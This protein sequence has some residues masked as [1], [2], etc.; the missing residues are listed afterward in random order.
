MDFINF[1]LDKQNIGLEWANGGYADLH[2]DFDFVELRYNPA[3]AT[4]RLS[5]Q[6]ST[7]EWARNVPWPALHLVF[8]GV[9]YLRVK[10]RDPEYP[11]SE[12]STVQHICRTPT[13]A[14]EEFENIYFN[15]DAQPDYDVLL[16]FESEWGI[17]VN[18]ATGRLQL[19]S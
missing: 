17:K 10:E 9:S 2:N 18:A 19:E 6:K 11:F 3:A 1:T 12:D 8:E 14:R 16:Y 13:E 5:W 7:G 15:K 4:L